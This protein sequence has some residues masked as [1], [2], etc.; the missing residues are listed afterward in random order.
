MTNFFTHLGGS[1][2]SLVQFWHECVHG[3]SWFGCFGAVLGLGIN[4]VS[5]IGDAH[6]IWEAST[7]ADNI[8]KKI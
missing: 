2:V 3:G 6:A 1:A 4:V 7:D 8:Y 5:L